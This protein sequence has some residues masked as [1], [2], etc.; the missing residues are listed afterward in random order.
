MS[1]EFCLGFFAS[2][3]AKSTALRLRD[4][5]KGDCLC[6]RTGE[7]LL[8]WERSCKAPAGKVEDL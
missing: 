5:V 7:S 8:E 2:A 3:V 1:Y 6:K 4:M